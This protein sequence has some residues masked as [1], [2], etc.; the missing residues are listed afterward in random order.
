MSVSSCSALQCR[1]AEAMSSRLAARGGI[2]PAEV[3]VPLIAEQPAHRLV[4]GTGRGEGPAGQEPQVFDICPGKRA[5]ERERLF[6]CRGRQGPECLLSSGEHGLDD[7]GRLSH[8]PHPPSAR[9][10]QPAAG[11]RHCGGVDD[12]DQERQDVIQEGPGRLLRD[13]GDDLRPADRVVWQVTRLGRIVAAGRRGADLLAPQVGPDD[14]GGSGRII[15]GQLVEDGEEVGVD[16]DRA[17]YI[18]KVTT[19]QQPDGQAD[20][21]RGQRPLEE[22][23]QTLVPGARCP[24]IG[25][26]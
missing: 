23:P 2:S 15:L 9:R 19:F 25:L 12:R 22:R 24:D 10:A 13:C 18:I 3:Q 7:P 20:E 4:P 8:I 17:A 21:C 6:R 16:G 14:A 11:A 1:V 5:G 26:D